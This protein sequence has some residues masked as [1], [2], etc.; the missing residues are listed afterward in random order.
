MNAFT[1]TRRD[2]TARFFASITILSM[3]LTA[4]PAAFFVAHAA[5]TGLTLS[6]ATADTDTDVQVNFVVTATDDGLATSGTYVAVTDGANGGDFFTGTVGGDCNDLVADVDNEFSIG[7]NKG[8]CYSNSTP[9]VYDISTQLLD[10]PAGNSIGSPEVIEIT[11]ACNTQYDAA[12]VTS[13][14]NDDTDEYFNSIQDAIDDCDTVN[15]NTILLSGDV[16]I[17]EQITIGN[18]EIT[19]DG[20]GFT[21]SPNF[22]KTTNS[23]NA[24]IGVINA[25]NVS[26]QNLTINGVAGTNL[27]GV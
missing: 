17:S 6:S 21:I 19:L 26:V 14:Q 11:V 10:G 16:S 15:G 2:V 25:F 7:T 13:I 20:G 3:I 27:H 22:T 23:N 8:V 12:G 24:A 4:F 9:G 1:F 18:K 5:S